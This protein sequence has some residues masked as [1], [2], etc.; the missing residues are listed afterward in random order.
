MKADTNERPAHKYG[1]PIEMAQPFEA[2]QLALARENRDRDDL[3][4]TLSMRE[5]R[6]ARAAFDALGIR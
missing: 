3:I 4:F 6:K 1:M 2:A 5:L